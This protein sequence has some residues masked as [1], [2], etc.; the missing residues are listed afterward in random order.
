MYDALTKQGRSGVLARL[1][2]ERRAGAP[3]PS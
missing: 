1:R 2:Q 3:V